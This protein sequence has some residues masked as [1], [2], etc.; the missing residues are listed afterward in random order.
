MSNLIQAAAVLVWCGARSKLL[1]IQRAHT[2]RAFPGQWAFPGGILDIHDR[3]IQESPLSD[4]AARQCV[5]R[6]LFEETGL[7]PGYQ[8]SDDLNAEQIALLNQDISWPDL[9]QK[10][11]YSPPVAQL[12]SLGMR[13]TPPIMPRTFETFYFL[14]EVP[15]LL[16]LGLLSPELAQARWV[17]PAD[18]MANWATGEASIPPPV[19]E[20]VRVLAHQGLNLPA[21]LS[22]SHDAQTLP[23]PMEMYPGIEMLPL[24]TPTVPPATH[25][26]GYFVGQ[27]RFVIIDPASPYPEE[28][29]ILRQALQRRLDLG[30][31]PLAVLLTHHHVDHVGGAEFVRDWLKIPIMAHADAAEHLPFAIDQ[32]IEDQQIW[33][34]GHDPYTGQHWQLQAILTPGHAPGHL[35]FVDLRHRVAIVGD[36]LAGMGTI[37]IKRPKG[38]MGQYLASLQR[39]IDLNLSKGFP[40]HGPQIPDLGKRCQEYIAHRLAREDQIIAK[41]GSGV[42]TIEELVPLVYGDTPQEIWPLARLSLEAHLYHLMENEKAQI[43]G[44]R[45]IIRSL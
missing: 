44:D 42:M 26:N 7:L 8:G 19:L 17:K 6:E 14:L 35:C 1:I 30:H 36:M 16:P 37:L 18:L 11:N 5:L 43:V 33:Q 2:Q 39:L 27:E 24:R 45:W 40:A 3:I 41:L 13:V 23:I 15:D 25:T 10:L 21:L 9:C 22:Q 34:L 12:Q 4:L 38:H 29:A 28:Q 20:V 31:E 32:R